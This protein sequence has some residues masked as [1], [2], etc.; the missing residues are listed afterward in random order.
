MLNLRV[1]N[2]IAKERYAICQGCKFFVKETRS[3][4]PLI[5][6]RNLS[7][8]ELKSLEVRHYKRKVRLCGCVMKLKTLL[9][10]SSCPAD[11]W[12]AVEM[13]GLSPERVAKKRDEMIGFLDRIKGKPTLGHKDIMELLEYIRFLYNKSVKVTNCDDCIR[14][15]L[16]DLKK[17]VEEI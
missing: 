11:K 15:Y 16:D 6:G 12:K 9:P 7:P 10:F 13:N 2:E 5:L 1:S 14:N 17:R 4:G 8:D 3:C